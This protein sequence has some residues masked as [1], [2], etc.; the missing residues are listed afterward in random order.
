MFF[1]C[2]FCTSKFD[3]LHIFE[4]VDPEKRISTS[5]E[6]PKIGKG[7]HHLKMGV[8]GEKIWRTL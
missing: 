5:F 3:N 7:T 6:S 1:S 4:S 2:T 8:G